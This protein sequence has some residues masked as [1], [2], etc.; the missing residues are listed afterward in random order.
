MTQFKY[1][2]SCSWC[3]TTQ[4]CLRSCCFF[5]SVNVKF[6]SAGAPVHTKSSMCF[7]TLKPLATH[8]NTE[9]RCWAQALS[10]ALSSLLSPNLLC[11]AGAMRCPAGSLQDRPSPSLGSCLG[12][13]MYILRLLFPCRKLPFISRDMSSNSLPAAPNK[14]ISGAARIGVPTNSP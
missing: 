5:F 7:A 8:Q 2:T 9:G 13:S 1:F 11:V 10:Y 12:D 6:S 4:L 14:S 3:W